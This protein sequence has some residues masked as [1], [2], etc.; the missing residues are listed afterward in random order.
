M[1]Q[2]LA[3]TILGIGAAA[4]TK[5]ALPKPRTVSPSPVEVE[6]GEPEAPPAEEDTRQA[7]E[8]EKRKKPRGRQATLLTGDLTPKT[9]KKQILG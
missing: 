3:A 9:K 2:V 4:V 1:G 8:F 7:A 6:P 5:R